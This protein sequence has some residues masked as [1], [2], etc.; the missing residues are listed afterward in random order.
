MRIYTRG[1]DQGKTTV[2]GIGRRPKNDPRVEAYGAV[3]EAG[4]FIGLAE[5]QLSIARDEDILDVLAAIQQQL[6]DVGADL[7]IR[8][9]DASQYRTP[10]SAAGS[11]EDWIDRYQE[12]AG[13][14]TQFV[15][16]GGHNGAAA[17][18]VACTVVR[19][20][21]RRTVALMACDDI[22]AP[23][24]AYL[25]RLSDLLFVLARAV[26]ARDRNPETPYGNSPQVFR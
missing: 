19:R 25:N 8:H 6:W 7:A 3:D 15:V 24:L 21:E 18:H 23:A 16:R 20:A 10:A 9:A 17:L 26:N 13:P 12:E 4:A 1:G 14:L 22:H 5:A 2:M 11:L